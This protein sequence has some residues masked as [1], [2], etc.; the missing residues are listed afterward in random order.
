MTQT[1]SFT[2][3]VKFNIQAGS[4][5]NV[6]FGFVPCSSL[7]FQK[8][9]VHDVP[10]KATVLVTGC[11]TGFGKEIVYQLAAKGFVVRCNVSL[12]NAPLRPNSS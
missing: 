12:P 6:G 2:I 7:L 10:N 5:N 3:L 1:N 11:S 9:L 8:Y 4:Q